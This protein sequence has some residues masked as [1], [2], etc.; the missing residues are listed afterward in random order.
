MWKHLLVDRCL[1]M[2]VHSLYPLF[3]K[4]S[5]TAVA[6]FLSTVLDSFD[7]LPECLLIGVN[8]FRF[9]SFHEVYF[10]YQC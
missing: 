1:L 3:L 7:V 2:A 4:D 9:P 6:V 10:H 5:I 8:L